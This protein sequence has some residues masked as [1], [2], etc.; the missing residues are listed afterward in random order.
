MTRIK[1]NLW[2]HGS[3]L[4]SVVLLLQ[5]AFHWSAIALSSFVLIYLSKRLRCHPH[6]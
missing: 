6:A 2:I 1:V 4:I 5:I 3:L